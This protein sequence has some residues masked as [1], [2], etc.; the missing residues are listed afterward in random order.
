MDK[1]LTDTD[2]HNLS[3]YPIRVLCYNEIL[4]LNSINDL[5]MNYNY[6][7]ILY[8]VALHEGHW[9][10]LLKHPER[11]VIEFFDPYGYKPD[12]EREFIP[13]DMWI[14]NKLSK[15]LYLA[16]LEGWIIEYNEIPLQSDKDGI[17][18]CGRW[19]SFRIC[20][21]KLDLTQFQNL[22]KNLKNPDQE[23]VRLTGGR[24]GKKKYYKRKRKFYFKRKFY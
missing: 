16:S 18:T 11:G 4:N 15:L 19:V 2:V 13:K 20:N 8:E 7:V 23:I 14:L 6:V 12:D 21:S 5:F 22:F 3:C 9:V 24:K 17:N 1:Y 10:A